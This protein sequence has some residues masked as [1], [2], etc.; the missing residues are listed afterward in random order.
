MYVDA[1]AHIRA[2]YPYWNASGGRDHI[3]VFGYD[4]AVKVAGLEAPCV[5]PSLGREMLRPGLG[6]RGHGTPD[7]GREKLSIWRNAAGFL[8]RRCRSR[9]V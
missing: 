1:H 4:G 7:P 2:T 8:T 3:W 6:R 5:W 9:R